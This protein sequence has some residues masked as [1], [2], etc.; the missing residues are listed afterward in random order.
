MH[1]IAVHKILL[2]F[3]QQ[4]END[5]HAKISTIVIFD[6]K[7]K[8]LFHKTAKHKEKKQLVQI[9]SERT[10]TGNKITTDVKKRMTLNS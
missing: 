6:L 5:T 8:C 7:S 2:D 10:G 3:K 4:A 1:L 9:L